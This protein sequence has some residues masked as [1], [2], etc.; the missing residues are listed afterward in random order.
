MNLTA[1]IIAAGCSA[2]LTRATQWVQPLQ[3]ACDRFG[4]STPQRIAAFLAQVGHES[5]GLSATAESFNYSVQRLMATWPRRMP[6]SIA[7]K[8]GRQPGESVVPIVRQQRIANIV[9]A[10]QYGNGDSSS[11]DGWRF[12]GAGLI[13]LTFH[14]NFE[15]CGRDLSLD[16][17]GDPERVRTDPALAALVSGWFWA[18]NG[19]NTLADAGLFDSITRRIN[20]ALAGKA[21]RDALYAAA[22]KALGI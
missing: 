10:N 5:A 12:R 1:Q 8:L 4:I 9:Y 18:T 11:G 3:A 6:A 16:L 7:S 19:C 22:R 15:A 13:Q 21:Q 2:P 20:K 17:V 14:D